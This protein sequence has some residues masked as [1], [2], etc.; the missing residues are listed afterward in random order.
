[1]ILSFHPLFEGDHYRLCAG[2]DPDAEDLAA[3]QRASAV[4]L[5]QGCRATLYHAAKK[6]CAKVFPNYDARFAYPGKIGQCQLF[7]NLEAPHPSSYYYADTK[8][9]YRQHPSG[10]GPITAPMMVKMD[11]GG[12]GDG[13]FPVAHKSELAAVLKRLQFFETT[14]QQGF[15]VQQ[16]IPAGPRTLRVV[17]I[18]HQ[19][20]SYWRVMPSSDTHLINLAQG[21]KI[22][23]TSDQHLIAAAETAT[24]AFCQKTGINLAGFDFLF[25]TDDGVAD[26]GTALF[27]E[28]N[29]YFGRRGIGGSEV[30][31]QRLR[32][33]IDHWL[34][35][36]QPSVDSSLGD[37]SK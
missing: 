22:D 32:Q 23:K 4:I 11:W 1:M 19:I 30:F 14:G 26:S 28:I 2:R 18:G 9:F 27:L 34:K 13:V 20:C 29:Y 17:V 25:S 36:S 31:Y 5:P 16:W 33:A 15:I 37:K 3:I 8:D 7:Q 6:H 35:Y 12:E 24:E 10:N 21:G